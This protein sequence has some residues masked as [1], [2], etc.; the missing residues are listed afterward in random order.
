MKFYALI[1][2]T[3]EGEIDLEKDKPLG[4]FMKAI[5]TDVGIDNIQF[6]YAPEGAGLGIFRTDESPEIPEGTVF[7]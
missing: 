7:H 2:Y 3:P 6:M 4:P 5:L 1:E